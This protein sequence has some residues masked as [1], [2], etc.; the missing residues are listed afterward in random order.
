MNVKTF[1]AGIFFLG[2]SIFAAY[3]QKTGEQG[4]DEMWGDVA[5]KKD[6]GLESKAAW[7]KEAKYAMFIHWGLFSQVS[8]NWKGKTYYGIGEW[9]MKLSKSSIADYEGL[10]KEFN[11][12]KFNA[13]EWV[14]LAKDAG[15]K[16]I[17]ITAKHHEGFA[18]FK[19]SH[20]YNVVDATP[21]KRDPM[22]ELAAACKEAGLKLGFYY[23]QFQD[24]HE[25]N[26]W[27]SDIK[28]VTFEE[29]FKNKCEPQVKELCSQYGPLILI[30]FDTPGAMTKD[31]SLA[32]VDLVKK[33]QPQ[34]LINSRIGNGVGDYSTYGDHEIPSKNVAGLWEAINTSNDSWGNAWYD[35]NWKGASEIARDLVSVI[36]RGGNY[37]L[38]IGP[39]ADG[40]I[41]ETNAEFLR[42]SG[43]WI[44]QHAGA[45]YGA[46]ASPW[47]KA[48]PWGDC[49]VSGNNLNLFVFDWKPG[50]NINFPGLKTKIKSV[51]ITTSKEKLSFKQNNDG[52]VQI[53]LPLRK[54]GEL[55]EVISVELAGKPEVDA[56]PGID[57]V[58]VTTLRAELAD[59]TGCSFGKASWME[60][61]GEWKHK[62][63]IKGWKSD[64]SAI[65]WTVNVKTPGKY[66]VNLEYNAWKD[67]DGGE[68]DLIAEKGS[69]LRIYTTASTGTPS[70]EKGRY[71]FRNVRM[72]V[73]EL[74]ASGKQILRF[75][76]A[77]SPKGG[78][79][80]LHAIYLT[81]VE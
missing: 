67:A 79:I 52:W 19:S 44:R 46:G 9:I 48:F 58:Y 60:K 20:P 64:K 12:V 17:V 68:W 26:N 47:Q 81:P 77:T 78:G 80:Q 40:S 29:Y 4:M 16:Y 74:N 8:N 54:K 73:V 18:M 51:S 70:T 5:G 32:L 22:Q 13:R 45:I 57:P 61:F 72:G 63:I 75:C 3:A 50:E 27:S 24:W 53:Q 41:P 11:P 56:I 49:T 42:T 14:Q 28:P 33:N 10:A 23:S 2:A 30:W 59:T 62:P 15:M 34:A 35:E 7:F 31:Q 65:S 55:L 38:N 71:R 6:A 39:R 37:M 66:F 69:K 36:A 25:I 21:F 43:E 1:F 76:S